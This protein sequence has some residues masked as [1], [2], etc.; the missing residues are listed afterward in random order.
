[1]GLGTADIATRQAL[2]L[3]G[4]LL[5]RR[6]GLKSGKS[7]T[8][9]DENLKKTVHEILNCLG[10]VTNQIFDKKMSETF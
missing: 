7:A 8:T 2:R 1:M 9:R 10:T 3:G 6:R 4:H 5:R